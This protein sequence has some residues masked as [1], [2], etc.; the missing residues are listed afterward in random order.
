MVAIMSYLGRIL[1]LSIWL[2]QESPKEGFP[3][4]APGESENPILKQ[5]IVNC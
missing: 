5:D 1:F 4:W 3:I 2:M